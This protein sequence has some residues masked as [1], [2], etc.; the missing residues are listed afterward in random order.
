MND[1][2]KAWRKLGEV[3]DLQEWEMYPSMVNA[4]FSPPANEV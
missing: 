3:R 1:E 4:Y 2:I